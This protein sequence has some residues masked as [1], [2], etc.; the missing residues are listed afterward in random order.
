M[1]ETCGKTESGRQCPGISSWQK[2]H[3]GKYLCMKDLVQWLN[4]RTRKVQFR[5][6]ITNNNNEWVSWDGASLEAATSFPHFT[7]TYWEMHM[8]YI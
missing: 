1:E 6:N 4:R 8:W 5:N 2:Q 3:R 7:F